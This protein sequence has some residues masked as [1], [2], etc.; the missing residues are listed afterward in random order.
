MF[1]RKVSKLHKMNLLV[2]VHLLMERVEY[3]SVAAFCLFDLYAMFMWQ[4]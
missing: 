1:F 3:C 4:I 2:L